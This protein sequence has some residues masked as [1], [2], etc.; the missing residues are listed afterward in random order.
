[1]A[2]KKLGSSYLVGASDSATV[3]NTSQILYRGWKD[4]LVWVDGFNA[5]Q[6]AVITVYNGGS[7]DAEVFHCSNLLDDPGSPLGIKG[8]AT[9]TEDDP[10]PTI[11]LGF[12]PAGVQ[13]SGLFRLRIKPRTNTPYYTVDL[14]NLPWYSLEC[15]E[16]RNNFYIWG[17]ANYSPITQYFFIPKLAEGE[18]V[19]ARLMTEKGI[20]N[21]QLDIYTQ[22]GSE[23]LATAYV[24]GTRAGTDEH[25]YFAT[26]ELSGC[27]LP[28]AAP[29]AVYRFRLIEYGDDQEQPSG[30]VWVR[31]SQNVPPYFSASANGLIYPIV[32]RDFDPIS[33]ADQSKTFRIFLT[34][35]RGTGGF[36]PTVSRLKIKVGAET[37][38]SLTTAYDHGVTVTMPPREKWDGDDLLAQLVEDTEE[39]ESV[40]ADSTDKIDALYSV[41]EPVF[42]TSWPSKMLIAYDNGNGRATSAGLVRGNFNVIQTNTQTTMRTI[43]NA[44]AKAWGYLYSGDLADDDM[45]WFKTEVQGQYPN[46]NSGYVLFWGLKDEA[47]A[48]PGYNPT[49]EVVT[50]VTS[51]KNFYDAYYDLTAY[52]SKPFY[53]NIMHTIFIEEFGKGCD[54]VASDPFVKEKS[55]GN[56][57][58]IGDCAVELVRVVPSPKKKAIIL[59]WWN[60][61]ATE[62]D[63]PE[64]STLPPPECTAVTAALFAESFD[65][66]ED[67]DGIGG[68]NFSEGGEE[69]T[70]RL[71]TYTP[72]SDLWDEIEEKNGEV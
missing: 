59:W 25:P 61:K 18:V 22:D 1:M 65:F 63:C 6:K 30:N 62:D 52:T 36:L 24:R 13:L 64:G 14:Q 37:S 23:A 68:W 31:F 8:S 12:S 72:V 41:R 58:K 10:D 67:M 9:V 2:L 44:G 47:D 70:K 15:W 7:V 17:K 42:G 49:T 5:N 51:L 16:P 50:P 21:A 45:E 43:F 57:Q 66:A 4:V 53:A 29:G 48:G 60:P 71:D 3:P 34:V 39:G 27:D 11:T 46:A 55:G 35:P 32:H 40:Y 56:V 33:Y 69:N 28:S 38:L 19:T 54:I 20:D 26:A